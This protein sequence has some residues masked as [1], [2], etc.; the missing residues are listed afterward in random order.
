MRDDLLGVFGDS[1]VTGKPVGDDLREGKLTPLVAS[2]AARVDAEGLALLERLGASDLQDEEVLALR[3]LLVSC[4][5][6]GEV[7]AAI[8]DLVTQSLEA[9]AVAPITA[10]ARQALAE[11]GTFVA[12]RD[13]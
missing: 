1:T 3:D 2:A 11:L 13:W 10:E 12:W 4:G 6:V 9:L 7:E 5:A 8:K